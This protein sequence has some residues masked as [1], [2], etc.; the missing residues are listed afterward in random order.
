M[1]RHDHDGTL[2]VAAFRPFTQ[3]RDAVGIGH[4]DVE[5]DQIEPLI[6]TSGTRLFRISGSCD[7][8][9]FITENFLNQSPDIGLVIDNQ[10]MRNAHASSLLCSARRGA[11]A[12]IASRAA[13]LSGS[14]TLMTAPPSALL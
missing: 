8:I 5:Q 12:M 9:P 10:N 1:T 7:V 3:Q 2:Q 6:R 11:L 4:P 14:R 13:S